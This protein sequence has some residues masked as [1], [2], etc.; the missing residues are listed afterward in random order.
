MK[1]RMM[2]LTYEAPEASVDLI[3]MERDFLQVTTITGTQLQDW[4]DPNVVYDEDF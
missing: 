2:K 1:N 3:E 4:N